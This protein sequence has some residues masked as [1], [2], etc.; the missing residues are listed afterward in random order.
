[1]KRFPSPILQTSVRE[2]MFFKGTTVVTTLVKS[3]FR[4]ND[5]ATKFGSRSEL[6]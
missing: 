4:V 5:I 3:V 6:F 1:M 2:K